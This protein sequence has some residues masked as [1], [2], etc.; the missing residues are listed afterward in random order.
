MR[1]GCRLPRRLFVRIICRR[2]ILSASQL[3]PPFIFTIQ[4][5]KERR[6]GA[7]PEDSRGPGTEGDRR[8]G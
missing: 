7:L 2:I 1:S 3:R 8:G 5:L 6:I 4:P